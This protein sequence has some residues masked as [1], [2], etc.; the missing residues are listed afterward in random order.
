MSLTTIRHEFV[1]Y[2]PSELD[3]NVLY[4]SIQFAIAVHKCAC[5][6]C[7]KVVTPFSP[8]EWQLGFDGESVSLSPS[9][10]NWA[11]PCQSHYWIKND[12]IC[13]A[14]AWDKEQIIEGYQRDAREL[15]RYFAKRAVQLESNREEDELLKSR[16]FIQEL[17]RKMHRR[18]TR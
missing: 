14:G 15:E 3:E 6:C 16:H 10:G 9:I 12:T 8:V 4:V 13:W 2:I 1:E 5:G 18:F 17:W 11:F 7:N